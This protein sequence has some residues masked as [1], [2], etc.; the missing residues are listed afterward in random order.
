MKTNKILLTLLV[1]AL[2][3]FNSAQSL[4]AQQVRFGLTASPSLT[5]FNPKTD[6][7]NSLGN[8]LGLSYGLQAEILFSEQY[9][10]L[11]GIQISSLGG[12]LR[13][14][15]SENKG[16]VFFSELE[17]DYRLQYLEIPL[18]LKMKSHDV[19]GI[20]FYAK[21]GLGTSI[22]L[23][24]TA[25][26]RYSNAQGGASLN[27]ADQNIKGDIAFGRMSLILGGGVEY[28]V[29]GSISL[30]GGLTLNNGFSN[31]LKGSNDVSG[32]R[33]NARANYLELTFGILF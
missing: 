15:V 25:D 18:A 8:R 20:H 14:A 1:L 4:M 32:A 7:Y 12:K 3:S 2:F 27:L 10:F 24:A 6:N 26:E 28:E 31:I 13:Y 22:N 23:R 17:R 30:V 29:G 21:F 16:G 33:K 5:W 9:G 11:S 19:M